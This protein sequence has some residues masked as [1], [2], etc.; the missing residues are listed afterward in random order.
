ME[1]TVGRTVNISNPTA[2]VE[3]W[4]EMNLVAQNPEYAKKSRMGFWLGDTPKTL[5]MYERHGDMLVLPFGTLR[6]ILPILTTKDSLRCC[7]GEKNHVDYDCTVPLYDYQETAVEELR[8]AHYGILQ[9]PAGSGKTQMGIALIARLGLRALWITHTRDLLQQSR[10]RALQ[11]MD[12]KL[13]GTITEGRIDNSVG[14]TFA[15]VQTLSKIDLS[16]YSH[17]WDVII[18]DEC[19]RVAGSPTK[20]TQ[21]YKVLNSLSAR[22]KYGLSATVHRADGL[23]KMA[24]ALLGDVVYNV[25]D[26]AVADKIMKVGI[27]PVFTGTCVTDEMLNTD[28]TLNYSRMITALC[29]DRERNGEIINNILINKGYSSL[30]L[31]D[32]LDHLERLM[33]LLPT[34]E[35]KYAVM[36]SGRM[37]SKA[38]KAEREQAIEDMRT[39]KKRYLFATYALGKEGLDVPRLERL[40]MT[41]P[42]KDY[43][44]VAQSVGRIARTCKGK[45]A[46]ICYD[47]VDNIG[48]LYKSY[49]KRCTTY[50]KIRCYFVKES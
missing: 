23:I 18:V 10:S 37:T 42:Q 50:K 13:I 38:A 19:H 47:F 49:K 41:T 5:Y 8:K 24:F 2:E 26:K 25:P 16:N 45:S 39:G 40:Y 17:E 48:Y 4:C 28:G 3:A 15:T 22:H 1:I 36:V 31:S 6:E 34:N 14:V 35:R 44:V 46:P 29:N 9:S 32:R 43:A 12:R 7:F 11:Y 27:H 33:N 21:F 20:L 30:I